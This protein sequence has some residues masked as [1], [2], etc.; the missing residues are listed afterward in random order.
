MLIIRRSW[1]ERL[2]LTSCNVLFFVSLFLC[3]FC[4]IFH[5]LIHFKNSNALHR[6]HFFLSV[7]ILIG[8]I[9]SSRKC[10]TLIFNIHCFTWDLRACSQKYSLLPGNNEEKK[11]EKTSLYHIFVCP[12]R[13][14][15][16]HWKIHSYTLRDYW[17]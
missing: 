1:M 9:Q 16:N 5:S 11:M 4:F 13:L 17:L 2:F 6:K 14:I 15:T 10:S 12:L 7:S 8:H 3:I